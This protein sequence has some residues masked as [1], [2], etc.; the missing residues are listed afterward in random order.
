MLEKGMESQ[1]RIQDNQPAIVDRVVAAYKKAKTHQESVFEEY[2]GGGEWESIEKSRTALL[3]SIS[4]NDNVGSAELL[5]NFFR[6][7]LSRGFF[8]SHENFLK[9]N[10]FQKMAFL[11]EYSHDLETWLQLL[12]EKKAR[13]EDVAY[14]DIGNPWGVK[15]NEGL[16][17][18][19]VFRHHYY[20]NYFSELLEDIGRPVIAEI[21]SGYGAFA[22]Y[23]LKEKKD[24]VYIGFD[25][26]E[27]VLVLS[28]FLLSYFPD[29][30]FIL[31]GE[32]EEERISMM[33]IEQN[34][35]ILMPISSLPSLAGSSV[36]L[37]L[38]TRSFSE[39]D[40]VQVETYLKEIARICRGYFFHENSG[41]AIP[42]GDHL[43]VVASEF[44]VDMK[45]FKL[46]Y[47]SV[48]PWVVG[49]G[50][51]QEFLYESRQ[52]RG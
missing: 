41:S 23:I 36:D 45:A 31:F 9:R 43:E 21:G 12:G 10:K 13:I 34:D 48:S 3:E 16:V 4:K 17:P 5:S 27:V 33:D 44:P 7:M 15:F 37:F 18:Y 2:K 11:N 8:P 35:L 25:L 20:A 47:H 39:M 40:Y 51:Y 14:P 29:K 26:P 22:R 32:K 42:K 52:M 1:E 46:L 38:N 19:G 50:R 28:Y 49:G 24:V 30:K 6:N